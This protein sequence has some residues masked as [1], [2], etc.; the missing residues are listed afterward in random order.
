M[1]V[2]LKPCGESM[3]VAYLF[4]TSDI[5]IGY[6][7]GNE[8]SYIP[9]ETVALVGIA[10]NVTVICGQ[11][12]DHRVAVF[13]L[14]LVDHLIGKVLSTSFVAILYHY[15]ECGAILFGDALQDLPDEGDEMSLDVLAAHLVD[16]K[17]CGF[18]CGW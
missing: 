17:T 10:H 11:M 5:F 12:W 14:K 4:Q 15:S 16:L 9:K 7:I 13:L 1:T 2:T 8:T 18:G 6:A 3:S